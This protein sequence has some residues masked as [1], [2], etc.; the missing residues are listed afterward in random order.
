MPKIKGPRKV[1]RY[2]DEF[3]VKAGIHLANGEADVHKRELMKE[4]ALRRLG[5][6]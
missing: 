2:T 5:K 6:A 4:A 1:A 3:K